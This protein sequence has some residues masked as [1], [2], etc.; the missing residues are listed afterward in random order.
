MDET[1]TDSTLSF[2]TNDC[3]VSPISKGKGRAVQQDSIG[4]GSR[5]PLAMAAHA[6]K[7][8]QLNSSNNDQ[9]DTATDL[10][11]GEHPRLY[12]IASPDGCL[13]L[14]SIINAHHDKICLLLPRRQSY[15]RLHLLHLSNEAEQ[16]RLLENLNSDHTA[17]N[18]AKVKHGAAKAHPLMAGLVKLKWDAM[19]TFKWYK[20][21]IARD[22]K[23]QVGGAS[24]Q[25]DAPPDVRLWQENDAAFVEIKDGWTQVIPHLAEELLSGK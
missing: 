9:G 4:L 8:N 24:Y 14:C 22:E 12:N 6:S 17:L 15:P 2:K 21:W 5:H 18:R 13:Y 1:T 23:G 11:V 10:T 3:F 19:R 16:R 25:L 7:S 20:A